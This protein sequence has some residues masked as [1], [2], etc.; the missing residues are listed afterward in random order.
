[1][2]TIHGTTYDWTVSDPNSALV[3]A[4]RNQFN[5]DLVIAMVLVN[6]GITLDTAEA[7]LN[8]SLSRLTPHATLPGIA[9]A[10]ARIQKAI[11]AGEQIMVHGD[12]DCDG[13]TSAALAVRALQGVG[14]KVSGFVPRRSD[15]YDLQRYGV[16]EAAKLGASL[17]I[18]TDCGVGAVEPVAYAKALGIDVV[19]TDHHRP[20]KVLPDAIAVVNPYISES[21]VGFAHICGAGVI[22]RVLEAYM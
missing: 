22:F 18:T 9:D 16:D 13:V 5:L 11:D 10:T 2:S 8:P 14:A 19:V 21:T 6:R 20:G 4:L 3:T 1:M 15:G 7:F 17:I 12:Y